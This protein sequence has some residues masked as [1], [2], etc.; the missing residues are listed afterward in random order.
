M[1][2]YNSG[3]FLAEAIESIQDALEMLTI[4][5][6]MAQE[7]GIEIKYQGSFHIGE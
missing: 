7:D 5:K 6:Q 2:A 1:P 4:A 3:R